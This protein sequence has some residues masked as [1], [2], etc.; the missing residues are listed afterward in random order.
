MSSSAPKKG[1]HH[2]AWKGSDICD[3]NIEA[4]RDFRMLPPATLVAARLPG[5]EAAPT[6]EKGEVVVFEEHFYRGFGLPASEF[7][8][9]FSPSSACSRT[10]WRPTPSCS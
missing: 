1:Q 3:D 6:P 5:A 7:F 9:R 10:T 2:D 4:L 8:A